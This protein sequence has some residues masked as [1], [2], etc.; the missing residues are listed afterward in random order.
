RDELVKIIMSPAP[1][2]GLQLLQEHGLLAYTIPELQEGV[3]VEQNQAHSFTV[4]E[5]I[6]RTL[7]AS[8]DKGF[9]LPVRLACLF[10][11]VAKQHTRA[12]NEKKNDWSFH[13]HEVV[14]SRIERKRMQALRFPNDVI[15]TVV[16]LVRWHMFFSDTELV[17]HS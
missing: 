3:G 2:R 16:K 13:G 5:H 11:D 10:H 1:F 7:Q 9:S 6:G 17:T 8:A 12:R 15:D 4:F 14:G